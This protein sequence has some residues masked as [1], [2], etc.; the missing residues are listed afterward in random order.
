MSPQTST[1]IKINIPDHIKNKEL[2]VSADPVH[3]VGDI[4]MHPSEGICT[5]EQIEKRLFNAAYSMYYVLKPR[6]GKSSSKVYLPVE[7]GNSLL[8]H[9]LV[10]SEIDQIIC[11]SIDCPTLWVEDNKQRKKSFNELLAEGDYVKLIRMISD[12]HEHTE[13]RIAEGKKPCA[14]DEA[15]LE[16]AE[17]LLHQEFAYVLNLPVEE[18]TGYIKERMTVTAAF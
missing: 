7:R 14:A 3:A 10:K 2:A 17:R 8:R 15:V 12:I 9:L 5:V 18:I 4:V 11:K 1:I 16:E 6:L 13:Q